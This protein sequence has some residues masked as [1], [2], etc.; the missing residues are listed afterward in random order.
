MT[1]LQ[2]PLKLIF[3][4]CILFLTSW[5]VSAQ[6][7]QAPP[8]EA[9]EWSAPQSSIFANQ[10]KKP[11][12]TQ[13]TFWLPLASY[14]VPG[15]GSFTNGQ[16]AA[17]SI[18]L[19]M[20]LTGL[21]VASHA[22]HQLSNDNLDTDLAS[23]DP[24]MQRYIWGVKTYD[25]AGS[26][27]AYHSFHTVVTEEQKRGRFLFLPQERET[28]KELMLAPFDFSMILRPTTW[29]PLTVGL[30]LVLAARGSG[31]FQSQ[32]F[33]GSDALYA[34]ALS[35]NAG[36]GEEALFRGWLFPLLTQAYGEEQSAWANMT[37]AALFGAAHI[38][39]DNPYP[40]IQ[41]MAG[42]YFAV[43]VQKN[44]WSLREAIFLHTWWDVIVFSASLAMKEKDASLYI[45]LYQTT[46]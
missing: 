22:A 29:I 30:G 36:V 18:Y 33:R 4:F 19:G 32:A 46:F 12:T 28:T 34:S 40:I 27:S 17:G 41:T 3:I 37:Q 13:S 43:L 20:G 31:Q 2:A 7:N 1:H 26:L 6:E 9:Q 25:L 16:V 8:S 45:P 15:L 21:G 23:R 5:Y 39:G 24:R 42:F 38:S 44:G 11:G 35:Y 10:R 14:V